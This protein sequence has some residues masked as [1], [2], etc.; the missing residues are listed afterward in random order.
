[1]LGGVDGEV[2]AGG[3]QGLVAHEGLDDAA[4][5]SD[6]QQGGGGYRQVSAQDVRWG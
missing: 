6:S 4:V 5:G 2:A 1:M 3:G